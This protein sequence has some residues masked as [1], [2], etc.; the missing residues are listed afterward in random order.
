MKKKMNIN[1][2]KKFTI[3]SQYLIMIHYHLNNEIN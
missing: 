2:I 3:E 1:M